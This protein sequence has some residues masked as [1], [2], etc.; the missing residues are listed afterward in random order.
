MD[1]RGNTEDADVIFAAPDSN[2]EFRLEVRSQGTPF[3]LLCGVEEVRGL[4]PLTLRLLKCLVLNAGS[5]VT[6]DLIRREVW[7]GDSSGDPGRHVSFLRDAL[8]DKGDPPTFIKGHFAKGYEFLCR[9]T[10]V[11]RSPSTTGTK[12]HVVSA[13]PELY[14][15][16]HPHA[17]H[18][19][20]NLLEEIHGDAAGD[21]REGDLK[22]VS[23]LFHDVM[24]MGLQDLLLRGKHIKIIVMNPKNQAL[25]R[26]R[27]SRHR[28]DFGPHPDR[29]ALSDLKRQIRELTQMP[30]D[31]SGES[32]QCHGTVEL[33]VS[34]IMP[35]GFMVLSKR[36]ALLGAMLAHRSY[37]RG[38]P[39]VDV[40]PEHTEL[41]QLLNAD[42]KARWADGKTVSQHKSTKAPAR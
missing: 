10:V 7:N 27:Y 23:S 28:K 20:L 8:D 25:I 39:A 24:D 4:G 41:W 15:N 38:G 2:I 37:N 30:I 18:A 36:R 9:P 31:L 14:E 12:L 34:D 32:G 21:S 40:R 26:S 1:Q 16:W 6:H 11:P 5:V 17:S 35:P 3:K 33:R 13:R 29:K 22:I 19:F 42:W